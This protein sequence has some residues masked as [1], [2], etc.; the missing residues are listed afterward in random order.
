MIKRSKPIVPGDY[1]SLKQGKNGVDSLFT[2]EQ[3]V[4]DNVSKFILKEFER[5][6]VVAVITDKWDFEWTMVMSNVGQF[7]LTT[8]YA[9]LAL[10]HD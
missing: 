10:C 3:P 5:Y 7:G 4:V 2:F 9:G 8:E 6:I 1:V